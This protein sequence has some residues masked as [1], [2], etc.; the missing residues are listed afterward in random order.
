MSFKNYMSLQVGP[1]P[2]ARFSTGFLEGLTAW[3]AAKQAEQQQ[4][5]AATSP[6]AAAEAAAGAGT[7]SVGSLTDAFAAVTVQQPVSAQPQPPQQL[8][9]QR[10]P[11][12]GEASDSSAAAG[13]TV[14][15]LSDGAVPSDVAVLDSGDGCSEGAITGDLPEELQDD[16]A[17]SPL[18]S[19]RV[20]WS[21]LWSSRTMIAL[22]CR[23]HPAC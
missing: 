1:P 16:A 18:P 13:S 4:Q 8:P 19:I 17:S 14:D 6:A 12:S 20:S 15:R 2:G 22:L 9:Q 21:A 3:A 11:S 5:P 7:P 23:P 10:Q